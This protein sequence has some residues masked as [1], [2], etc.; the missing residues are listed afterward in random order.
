MAKNK[1]ESKSKKILVKIYLFVLFIV[2][3]VVGFSYQAA[4]DKKVTDVEQMLD[5]SIVTALISNGVEQSNVVSQFIRETRVSGRICHEYNK[6]ISLPKSKKA[7][8]FEPIFKTVARNFKLEL[9]KKTYKDGSCKYTFKDDK[10][11]YS[12]IEFTK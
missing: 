6:K 3:I 8:N 10:K 7:Q 11:T 4:M 9:T 12:I 2:G 5:N 1:E